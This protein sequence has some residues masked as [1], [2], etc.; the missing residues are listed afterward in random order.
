MYVYIYNHVY[1]HSYIH[2][3]IHTCTHTCMHMPVKRKGLSP[4]SLY[5]VEV[6][7]CGTMRYR[8][9]IQS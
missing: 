5:S 4:L 7:G 9:Q 8:V 2:T 6:Q 1:I 3:Y